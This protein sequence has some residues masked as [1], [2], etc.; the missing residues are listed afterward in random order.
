MTKEQILE[1]VSKYEKGLSNPSVPD[2]AKNTIKGKIEQLK[3]DLAKMEKNVEVK[4]EK[5]QKEEKKVQEDLEAMIAKY[6]KGLNNPSVP[7]S[8]KETIKKKI[9]DAEKELEQQ[10]KEIKEDKKEAEQEKKE[11]KEAVKKVEK[12]AKSKTPS[13]Q[14]KVKVPQVKEEQ[15]EKK[16]DS[17]KVKLKKIMTEL[18]QLIEKNKKLSKYKGSGVDLEKD[19]KRSAKPFGYRFTGKHDYRIPTQEQVKRG[20]KTGKVYYEG[21]PERADKFPTGKGTKGVKLERGG[22]LGGIKLVK[23]SVVYGIN[24]LHPDL[25]EGVEGT[26]YFHKTLNINIDSLEDLQKIQSNFVKNGGQ[27]EYEEIFDYKGDEIKG[28]EIT[29]NYYLKNQ[30]SDQI[31]FTIV[32]EDDK[33]DYRD[34]PIRNIEDQ[35]DAY[36]DIRNRKMSGTYPFAKGGSVLDADRFAK[37]MGW[38]WKDSAVED[39]IINRASLSHSPSL[40]MR[41]QYPDYVYSESRKTKSDKNPSRKYQSLGKGGSLDADRFA[42]PSG[43]RWKDSAVEDGIINRA[44]LS[45]SPS[46]KMRKQY[47]DYVYS[48]SRADKSDK[49]PSRKYQSLA[50]GGGIS[51]RGKTVTLKS[52]AKGNRNLLHNRYDDFEDF[53]SYCEMYEVHKTLGY[54]TPKQAWDAN[55][56]VESGTNPSDFRKVSKYAKG[57]SLDADRFAKPMGWRWKDSAVE[58][59]IINRAS[60]S[61]SPSLK[62]RREYPDY[63]AFENRPTKSDKKP[64]RKYQ[65][66]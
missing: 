44:S 19:A 48:E 20:L 11:I 24:Y 10:K 25:Y 39:G 2:S 5:M 41:K 43:W 35:I 55:P 53:E 21:R 22:S 61:H 63:V 26:D 66:I 14:P 18:E 4:E 60:L 16:Q 29:Y 62:M 58:D 33:V 49:N 17:R 64:S 40:K 27:W 52:G 7:E 50:K 1:Q 31:R 56:I 32:A 9:A 34:N 3:A 37:P 42:K 28:D 30:K 59:G 12:I 46:L 54:K 6:K 57:G 65:S 15:R 51:K 38:R 47:P 36:N 23:Y 13:K 45:H 8:A